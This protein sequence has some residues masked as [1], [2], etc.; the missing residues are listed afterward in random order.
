MSVAI[1]AII[2]A[3]ATMVRRNTKAGILDFIA[4]G[5]PLD[6]PELLGAFSTCRV[7]RRALQS[8]FTGPA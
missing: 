8:G 7:F 1:S 2:V 4:A 6:H 3:I 5:A